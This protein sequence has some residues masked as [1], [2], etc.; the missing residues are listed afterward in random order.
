MVK[1]LVIPITNDFIAIVCDV[2]NHVVASEMMGVD[3]GVLKEIMQV[4]PVPVVML[5]STT[6][7][8][9]ENTLTAMEYG[10]VDFVAKPSGTISLDLHKVQEELVHKVIEAAQIPIAKLKSPNNR[11]A[12]LKADPIKPMKTEKP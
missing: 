12:T 10:A 8:N 11:I 6:Q 1:L 5:S 7:Q 3:C 2:D 9:A 4:C